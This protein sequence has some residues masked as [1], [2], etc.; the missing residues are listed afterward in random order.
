MWKCLE[1][2]YTEY[3]YSEQ[4]F[5]VSTEL[6]CKIKM[7]EDL[8]LWLSIMYYLKSLHIFE[9]YIHQC[10]FLV[11]AFLICGILYSLWV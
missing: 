1:Y 9:I 7:C 3:L 6:L 2:L 11:D 5:L 4:F 8:R 10:Y